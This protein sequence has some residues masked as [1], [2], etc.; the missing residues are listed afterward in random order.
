MSAAL[1][2]AIHFE[3]LAAVQLFVIGVVLAYV[4][5]EDRQFDGPNR[6]AHAQ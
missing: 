2:S 1:F 4:Y 3:P 5:R 6:L